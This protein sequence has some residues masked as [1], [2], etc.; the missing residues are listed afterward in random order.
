MEINALLVKLNIRVFS[1]TRKDPTLTNEVLTKHKLDA[2]AGRWQKVKLPADSLKPIRQFA[3]LIRTYHYSTTLLWDEGC[4]LITHAARDK[5]QAEME[6]SRATFFEHVDAFMDQYPRWIEQS[7][8]MHGKTWNPGDYPEAAVMRQQ[9]TLTTE[10]LP[11]PTSSHFDAELKSLYGAALEAH[12]AGRIQEAVAETWGKI[13]EPVQHMADT[14]ASKDKIFRDTLV[15]N[16]QDVVKLIPALNLTND[17]QM[18]A[19]AKSIEEKLASLS[20]DDLRNNK[21]IRR[22]AAEAARQIAQRFSGMGSRKFAE[23]A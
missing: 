5:Y 14:L 9:F 18:R 17:A 8:I 2:T 20:A 12:N 22:E 19:A 15:T 13:L 11:I 16:I 1:N 6:K 4:R 10:Y 23:A 3:T 21:V 7:K